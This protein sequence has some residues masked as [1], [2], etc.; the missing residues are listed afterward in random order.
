MFGGW[1][2]V[3]RKGRRVGSVLLTLA[4][5]IYMLGY[6]WIYDAVDAAHTMP[7]VEKIDLQNWQRARGL[8]EKQ[9]EILEQQT[10]LQRDVL[11]KMISEGRWQQVL[12]IQEQYFAPVLVKSIKTTPL[13][14]TEYVVNEQGSF[15]KGARLIDVQNG[16]ILITKSS[17]FLGWRN[18]HAGL[19]VD[20]EQG[21][22]LEAVMLGVNTKLCRLSKWEEYPAFLVLRLKE[23]YVALVNESVVPYAKEKLVDIP[24]KLLAGVQDRIFT[25][26]MLRIKASDNDKVDIPAL[27]GTQCAHLI[28]YAYKQAG[29]DL[30]SD[31]GLIVTPEDIRNSTYLE[32][33][34]S[35]GY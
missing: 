1:Y 30:D 29:I 7:K 21:L 18:G 27:E 32:V 28:W 8:D 24:Y 22:V 2:A 12:E 35:Y 23:E 5:T 31:G 14:I 16:D 3:Q 19:V 20:A 13:T 25:E 34:Q 17:R 4:L 10:G 11:Q 9:W 6:N 15:V 33:I 26:G